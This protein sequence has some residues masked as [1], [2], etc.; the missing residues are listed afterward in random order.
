MSLTQVLTWSFII[1][2]ILA[3]FFP[4]LWILVIIIA[5]I[6]SFAIYA[7]VRIANTNYR[8][9][10]V[11]GDAKKRLQLEGKNCYILENVTLNDYR[12]YYERSDYTNNY[13]HIFDT[14]IFD[15]ARDYNRDKHGIQAT[16]FT[17][18][19]YDEK[20][21]RGIIGVNDNSALFFGATPIKLEYDEDEGTE[22]FLAMDS[23]SI[24]I[25]KYYGIDITT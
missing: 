2:F 25:N 7:T 5:L 12:Q 19:D 18:K 22:W 9:H 24:L 14:Y 8:C 21:M 23:D 1:T 6:G 11:L 4:V 13:N 15:A 3:F 16:C 20:L 17:Y 10:S